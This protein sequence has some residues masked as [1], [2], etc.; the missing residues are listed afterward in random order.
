[1]SAEMAICREVC[2][3]TGGQ[4]GV[5]I[6]ES[7]FRDLLLAI[8]PPP[9][10]RAERR[11]TGAGAAGGRPA[12]ELMPM[13]FP[14]TCSLAA[15]SL[16]ACHSAP[17]PRGFVCPRCRS[18]ICDVPTDCAV[19]ALTVVSSPHLA[20]SYRHLFPLQPYAEVNG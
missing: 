2:R 5:V 17:R 8:V 16:C 10:L 20:R 13:G 9:A 3:R 1:M 11:G 12:A 4:Y 18:K 15:P 14:T 6:N 7:H 19:C